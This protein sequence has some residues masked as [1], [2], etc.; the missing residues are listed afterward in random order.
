DIR[1]NLELPVAALDKAKVQGSVALS[2]NDIQLTPDTPA[3]AKAKGTVAFTERGF[4]IAG[5][6]AR[7]LGGDVKIEGGTRPAA[8]RATDS[9]VVIRAQGTATAEGLRQAKELGF[10]TRLA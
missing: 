7:A 3:L 5:A 1:L 4:T 8:A 2:G 10:L 9:T 6:Q